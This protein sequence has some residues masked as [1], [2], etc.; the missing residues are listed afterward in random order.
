MSKSLGDL[1]N[2][3]FK[4]LDRLDSVDKEDLDGEINRAKAVSGIASQIISNGTLVLKAKEL[5]LEYGVD[6]TGDKKHKMPKML[7]AQFLD[8]E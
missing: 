4:Q 5:Q 2:L 8:D 6:V 1:Q 3:L 7:R